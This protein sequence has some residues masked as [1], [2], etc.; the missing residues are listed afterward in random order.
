[1]EN[2]ENET[3]GGGGNLPSDTAHVAVYPVAPTFIQVLLL[4]LVHP[5]L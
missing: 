4:S 2:V 3:I 1:M 5:C